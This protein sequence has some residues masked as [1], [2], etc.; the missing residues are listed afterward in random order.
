LVYN[1]LYFEEFESMTT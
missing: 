1:V